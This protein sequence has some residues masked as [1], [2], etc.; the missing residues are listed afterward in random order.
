MSLLTRYAPAETVSNEAHAASADPIKAF[1]LTCEQI[2]TEASVMGSIGDYFAKRFSSMSI[3]IREGFQ[4]LTTFSYA[5]LTQLHPAQMDSFAKA[6]SYVEIEDLSVDQM[7]GFKGNMLQYVESLKPRVALCTT[8]ITDVVEPATRR[9]G[10]Y[11][12]TAA[13][14]GDRRDFQGGAPASTG[15]ADLIA[16]EAKFFT[17]GGFDATCRF[18]DIF[19]NN[20]E[21]VKSEKVMVEIAAMLQKA[22]PSKLKAAVDNLSTVAQQLF[23]RLGRDQDPASKEFIAMIGDELQTV[24]KWIEWY[25][26]QITRVTE[27]NATLYSIEDQL[28]SL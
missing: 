22:P 12:N 2:S 1:F 16:D 15:I 27:T 18:G 9:L 17:P 4:K 14:R 10:H 13:E 24:A 23:I 26:L 21:F 8:L 11:M 28:R 5:P 19:H 6:L 25:A 3:S 7:R 20:A